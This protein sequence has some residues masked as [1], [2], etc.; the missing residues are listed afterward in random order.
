MFVAPLE[1]RRRAEITEQRTRK[2]W[3]GTDKTVGRRNAY[4]LN[5]LYSFKISLDKKCIL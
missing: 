1:G 5:R 4:R 3:G 2:D